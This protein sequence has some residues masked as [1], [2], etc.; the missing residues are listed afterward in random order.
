LIAFVTKLKAGVME[1]LTSAGA[2]LANELSLAA[3]VQR[4]PI[5]GHYGS[6]ER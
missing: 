6:V 4:N 2:S 3:F 5:A 1:T